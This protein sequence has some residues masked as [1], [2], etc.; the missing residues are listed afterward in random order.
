MVILRSHQIDFI[1]LFETPW[2]LH[3]VYH[4]A[5]AFPICLLVS[6]RSGTPHCVLAYTQRLDVHDFF[7]KKKSFSFFCYFPP[8]ETFLE[9]QFDHGRLVNIPMP[10]LL[11][12]FPVD[13]TRI[14]SVQSC[15]LFTNQCVHFFVIQALSVSRVLVCDPVLE[16]Q[17]SG[18]EFMFFF[19]PIVRM[20][21]QRQ[22]SMF[23]T[24]QNTAEA[25][26]VKR[27]D[28]VVEMP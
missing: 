5:T 27:I 16:G 26:R 23:Q 14:V 19:L 2:V 21:V 20:I 12:G 9:L 24:L 6:L 13:T 22:V 28:E 10:L 11:D 15:S 25:H 17:F 3:K 8:C 4:V 7:F 18:Y 1:L